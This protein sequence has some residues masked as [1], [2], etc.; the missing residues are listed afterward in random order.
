MSKLVSLRV[1]GTLNRFKNFSIIHIFEPVPTFNKILSERW[2]NHKMTNGWDATINNF[3]LGLNDR[4][5]I[6]FDTDIIFIFAR[7]HYRDRIFAAEIK[8]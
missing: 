1:T 7:R 3:G 5:E 8:N 2:D 4:L 6:A